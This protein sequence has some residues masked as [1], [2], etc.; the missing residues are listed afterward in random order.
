[1]RNGFEDRST[2]KRPHVVLK[3]YKPNDV[4][5]SNSDIQGFYGEFE[6]AFECSK[7][8]LH[9]AAANLRRI[10]SEAAMLMMGYAPNKVVARGG[11]YMYADIG[12]NYVHNVRKPNMH[13]CCGLLDVRDLQRREDDIRTISDMASQGE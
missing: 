6:I 12:A 1:M 13:S 4:S 8:H 3:Y 11:D 2:V 5:L 9:A 7:H 10:E